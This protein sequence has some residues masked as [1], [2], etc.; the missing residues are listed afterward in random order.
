MEETADRMFSPRM[1]KRYIDRRLS[2][3]LEGIG[4]NT[5][6]VPFLGEI[7][8]SPGISMKG[9]ASNMMVDK[10]LVTRTVQKMMDTGLVIDE[11]EG[12]AYILRL[13]DKGEEA[14]AIAREVIDSAWASL[15][16]DLT[17]EEKEVLRRIDDK[18]MNVIKEDSA[19]SSSTS[20][21][22]ITQ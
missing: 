16:R 11:G 1:I 12:H 5:S 14:A 6:W 22:S 4:V 18:I 19:C 2:P 13:T 20:G 3:E 9:L 10:A 21:R 17:E 8:R 15:L 7:H